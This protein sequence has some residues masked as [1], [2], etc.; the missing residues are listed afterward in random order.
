M[1]YETR[2]TWHVTPDMF[3][4]ANIL[5]NFS[6]LALTVCDL[7]YYEDLEEKAHWLNQWMNE[8]QGSPLGLIHFIKIK[9]IHIKDLFY[10]HS[11]TPLSLIHIW[12]LPPYPQNGF[13]VL[14]FWTSP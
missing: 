4:G 12:G 7:W 5:S 1:W 13:A 6:S 8:L 11:A 10:P 3:G 14:F 9:N 2:D